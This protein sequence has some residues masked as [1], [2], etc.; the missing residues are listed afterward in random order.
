MTAKKV[1][2]Y[3]PIGLGNFLLAIPLIEYLSRT[4]EVDVL[5]KSFSEPLARKYPNYIREVIHD[6]GWK[7]NL[8]RIRGRGYREIYYTFPGH[9]N[10]HLLVMFLSGI[11]GRYG[12]KVPAHGR[13]LYFLHPAYS[14]YTEAENEALLNLRLAQ[15]EA[16][17]DT[18]HAQREKYWLRDAEVPLR[19]RVCLHPGSE[20]GALGELKR[21]PLDHW[22]RLLQQLN[23]LPEVEEI[24]VILG[25][26]EVNL[27]AELQ[28][29]AKASF[30]KTNLNNLVSILSGA[31]LMIGNDSGISHLEACSGVPTI[32]LFGPVS[33]LKSHPIGNRENVMALPLDCAPCQQFSADIECTNAQHQACMRGITPEA[34]IERVQAMDIFAGRNA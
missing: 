34:V 22:N 19:G 5:V 3:S 32:T 21:W 8:K 30:V 20:V 25:P 23:Q 33:W 12:Y 24:N 26:K 1:L 29:P 28:L 15:P 31:R 16:T 9:V 27:E 14:D 2:V 4:A 13:R 11:R 6:K 10:K 17:Y 18:I 7:Q